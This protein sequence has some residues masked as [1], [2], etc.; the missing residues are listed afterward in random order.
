IPARGSTKLLNEFQQMQQLFHQ[1]KQ[2]FPLVD[3]L[4]MGMSHDLELAIANGATMVRIGSAIFG[5]RDYGQ[6]PA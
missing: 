5:A 6:K 3:T 2:V 1:L 4:S